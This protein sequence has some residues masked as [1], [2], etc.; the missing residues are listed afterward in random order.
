MA[1]SQKCQYALK[2]IFELSRRLGQG[3]IK[4][5]D[6]AYAQSIPAR[7]LEVIFGQLKRGGFVES[8]RG[9]QGG[10]SLAKPPTAIS[11]GEIIRFTN[12]PI[13]PVPEEEPVPN[14]VGF[15]P[16]LA[17]KLVWKRAEK[18][19]ADVYDHTS[20]QDLLDADRNARSGVVERLAV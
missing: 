11:V 14:Q 18:A 3:P 17:L 13:S 7:F 6:V 16:D 2:G 4:I 9:V 15:R 8:R 19:L 20:F 1:L 10:Y 12:G 5:H